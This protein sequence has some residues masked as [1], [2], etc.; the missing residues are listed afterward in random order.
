MDA[1]EVDDLPPADVDEDV[2]VTR[3]V[4]DLGAVALVRERE[5]DLAREAEVHLRGTHGGI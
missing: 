1:A 2:V 5:A 4:E 3:K